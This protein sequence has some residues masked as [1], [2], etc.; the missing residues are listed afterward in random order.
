MT[1]T[2]EQYRSIAYKRA[3]IKASDWQPR[4]GFKACKEILY[5]LYAYYQQIY[6]LQ[7][8]KFLWAGLARLTGGQVL[9][10]MNNLLKIAN[11]PCMLTQEIMTAAKDIFESLGW[12]HELFLADEDLLLETCALTDANAGSQYPY[13]QCWKK[14]ISGNA[15]IV[16]EGNLMLLHNE[17]LNTIQRHYDLIKKDPYSQRYFWITKFAMRKI[18]PH[19]RRFILKYP[20]GDVTVFAHR[21]K[22]IT[23]RNGMWPAWITI[24]REERNRL[25]GLTTDDIIRHKW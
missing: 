16:N 9:Y 25:V 2:Q 14:I 15:N 4:L 3:G 18:H 13:A 22:W 12:Q 10:G 23:D 11:D 5:L 7:P 20:F 8:G 24:A 19:H 21:W 1:N 6:F 17:Q